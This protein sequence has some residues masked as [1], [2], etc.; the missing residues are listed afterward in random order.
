MMDTAVVVSERRAESEGCVAWV[1]GLGEEE[2]GAR[3]ALMQG[4]VGVDGRYG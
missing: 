4:V 3:R 1:V 2:E